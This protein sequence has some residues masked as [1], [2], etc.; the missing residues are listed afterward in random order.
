MELV[1]ESDTVSE[2]LR[3]AM[4]EG[5]AECDAEGETLQESDSEAELESDWLAVSERLTDDEDESLADPD[6]DQVDERDK[7]LERLTDADSSLD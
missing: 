1:A 6:G 7:L 3:D 2:W 4:G 5:L